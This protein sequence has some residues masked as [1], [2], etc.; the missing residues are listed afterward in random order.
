MVPAL[1]P[2]SPVNSIFLGGGRSVLILSYG[3]ISIYMIM[4]PIFIAPSL[5][6]SPKFQI[7]VSNGSQRPLII[8]PFPPEIEPFNHHTHIQTPSSLGSPVSVNSTPI[9]P[10]AQ[11]KTLPCPC[12]PHDS[13]VI[14]SPSIVMVSF[15]FLRLC[16]YASPGHDLPQ[17][18]TGLSTQQNDFFKT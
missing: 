2:S 4:I 5:T 16:H 11:A 3:F 15:V 18:L 10:D 6:S 14:P 1:S 17:P 9:Y 8:M 12:S 7:H 13:S